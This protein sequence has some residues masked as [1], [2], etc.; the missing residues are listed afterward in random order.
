AI[1]GHCEGIVIDGA[2]ALETN[3]NAVH[4]F[5]G[6][7]AIEDVRVVGSRIIG[8]G[9]A[10][11][12]ARCSRG[13]FETQDRVVSIGAGQRKNTIITDNPSLITDTDGLG[14]NTIISTARATSN[15]YYVNNVFGH[16][17]A[18]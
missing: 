11:V 4:C 1:T 2:S 16:D 6:G 15:K 5:G 18:L 9:N 8:S 17:F 7:Y 13:V 12:I 3:T 10:F 14:S